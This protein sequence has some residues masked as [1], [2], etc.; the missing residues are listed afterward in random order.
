MD[1]E[2]L[3]TSAIDN[4]LSRTTRLSCDV[5]KG[6]RTPN[7]DGHIFIHKDNKR[8]ND[9]VKTI[10]IQV[11]G[12]AVVKAKKGD[13]TFPVRKVDLNSYL[14]NGGTI[15]FVVHL[16]KATGDTIQIYYAALLPYTISKLLTNKNNRTTISVK[17]RQFP[18]D[19]NDIEE[20]LLNFYQESIRQTGFAE[21]ELP[22]IESL[23][24]AG[25]FEGLE[26][27]YTQVKRDKD[28]PFEKILEGKEITIYAKTKGNPIGIPVEQ[29]S[30]MTQVTSHMVLNESVK[31]EECIYYTTLD[32][33]QTADKIIIQIG[34]C[35][36]MT[37]SRE[38]NEDENRISVEIKIQGTLSQRIKGLEFII[39]LFKAKEFVIGTTA[40]PVNLN[41]KDWEK[42][43]IDE[44]TEILC[45]YNRA[46]K[47]LSELS[48]TKDLDLDSCTPDDYRKLNSLIKAIEN[49]EPLTGV[50]GNLP[51]LVGYKFAN[52]RLA[53]ICKKIN[54]STYRIWGFFNRTIDVVLKDNDGVSHPISQYHL[55]KAEDYVSIDNL[56]LSAIIDDI[57][58]IEPQEFLIDTSNDIMLEMLKAY[59]TNNNVDFLDTAKQINNWQRE[60]VNGISDEVLILNELQIVARERPLKHLEKISL[61]KILEESSDPFYQAGAYLLLD[62][63]EEATRI[64]NQFDED[65]AK[66]FSEYPI[67]KF[68]KPKE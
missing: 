35:W 42:F 18:T 29:I 57:K 4:L 7:W 67:Y 59:D 5:K 22:T 17:L 27:H 15:F 24:E 49:D 12:K 14:A 23:T 30:Y 58:R 40:F 36:K 6:D 2:G 63:Q 31:V 45:G 66:Q 20:L 3:A 33:T 48:V 55:L 53:M 54:D 50:N 47:A 60:Q 32:T 8:T 10:S 38:P 34:S 68:Y 26:F 64:I 9:G 13:V 19:T 56:K 44:Y 46:K 39:A 1:W 21:K 11:K 28:I 41:D 52:L 61:Y 16:D 65:S 62:E 51:L 43:D 25:V 37:L